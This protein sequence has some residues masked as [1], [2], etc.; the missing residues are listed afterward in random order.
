MNAE[1]ARLTQQAL[2]QYAT[3]TLLAADPAEDHA[4]GEP[5]LLAALSAAELQAVAAALASLA[6]AARRH[7]SSPHD[8]AP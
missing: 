4:A 1:R 7:D 5:G 6:A 3:L 8:P 2:D